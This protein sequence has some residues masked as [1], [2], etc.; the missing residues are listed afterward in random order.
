MDSRRT[1]ARL[2][3]RVTPPT[4]TDKTVDLLLGGFGVNQ[5][6]SKAFGCIGGRFL[7]VVLD[8]QLFTRTRR[9][10]DAF[11]FTLGFLTT[12][13]HGVMIMRRIAGFTT[14]IV[15]TLVGETTDRGFGE[16]NNGVARGELCIRRT[17]VEVTVFGDT[18][19][20][21]G[22]ALTS[23]PLR[24]AQC[25]IGFIPKHGIFLFVIVVIGKVYL[26]T[27]KSFKASL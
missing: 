7:R 14:E 18:D 20:A 16:Q 9:Q 11:A 8:K 13:M 23:V 12:G 10:G 15:H 1:S 19:V 24:H 6:D 22:K 3:L 17:Q 25:F 4:R 21:L 2:V 27:L 26:D 5:N